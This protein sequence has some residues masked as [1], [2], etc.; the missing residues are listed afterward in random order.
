MSK[1]GDSM[2]Q[3]I[4][5]KVALTFG[6][7]YGLYAIFYGVKRMHPNTWNERPT[8][9]SSMMW[10][11]DPVLI[12]IHRF[13]EISALST[14]VTV[15]TAY[16][17]I[18]AFAKDLSGPRTPSVYHRWMSIFGRL[19]NP[20][21]IFSD[22]DNVLEVFRK[23]RSRYPPNRT[24]IIKVE[25]TELWAFSLAPNISEIFRQKDYPA[26]QPNTINENYSCVMH[27]KFELMNRVIREKLYATKYISWLDIGLFRAVTHEK[28]SF[29]MQIPP[30]WNE[31]KIAYSEVHE[32]DPSLTPR[33]C[34]FKNLVWVSGAMFMGRPEVLYL[35][36]KDYMSAVKKLIGQKLMSTDQQ[37]IYI[38]Y[39]P[40]FNFQPRVEIQTYTTY[41]NDDWFYLGYMLK[42]KWER[43]Q[44]RELL[45]LVR[46]F[47]YHL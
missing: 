21:I 41:S 38:M 4:C 13:S 30:D 27:A 5:K 31:N 1:G 18:G 20:L 14:E 37:V 26:H 12:D 36:T 8:E 16:F 43:Y 10:R 28:H 44:I 29:L 34:I 6:F 40:S 33:D 22:Q 46:F 35:Y 24:K 25:K 17:N 7:I 42:D 47:F 45:P 39:L 9:I 23:L 2:W 3:S 32:F 15:V 11:K 19:D